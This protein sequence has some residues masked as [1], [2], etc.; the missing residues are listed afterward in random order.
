MATGRTARRPSVLRSG[1]QVG[2]LV[3]RSAAW[4]CVEYPPEKPGSSFGP[5]TPEEHQ[6][7]E[8]ESVKSDQ[9]DEH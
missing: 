5:V 8:N 6:A 4:F 3:V 1:W 9:A 7:D 2:V